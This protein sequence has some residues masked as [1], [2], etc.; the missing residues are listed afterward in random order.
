MQRILNWL[1]A[2][3]AM[4]AFAGLP[5]AAAA[6]DDFLAPEQAFKLRTELRDGGAVVLRW[7]IAPGYHLYRERLAFKGSSALVQPTLPAGIRTFDENFNKEME[8]Y[9]RQLVVTLPL[10]GSNAAP[11]TLTVSY[12]GCADAG[13]CYPPQELA[14]KVDPA[15]PGTL[16]AVSVVDGGAASTAASPAPATATQSA[17]AALPEDD[18][19]LA[20]RTLQSGSLWRIGGAFLVFGLLLSFTPCVLPMVPILSS[21]I[22]G[23]GSVSRS[24]GLL[25]A[26]AYCIG[27]ALVYTALG[28]GAG[29]AGEGLAGALQ[30]PWVLLTFGALLVGLA[31][32]M[33]DVY[34]LQLP[35]GLQSRL[36]ETGGKL[37]GGRFIGV[38]AMGAL[39]ALIVGPCVAG[40]LAGALLYISQTGNA[41]IGGWALFSMACGMSVPLLLTGLSAGSL[42]PRAGAWMNG[43]KK[44]F[45]L[46]LIAV[47]VWMVSPV[48]PVAVMMMLWGGLAILCAVFLHVGQALPPGSKPGAYAAKALGLLFLVGGLFELVGA[49]SAGRDV[50]QPLAHLRGGSANAATQ[51]ADGHEEPRFTRIRT[52][53][54]LETVLAAA[55]EPVLLDFYADW[56]VACKEMERMTFSKA[57]VGAEMKKM[58]LIQVDVTANNAD[59]RALMKKFSLFGPPGIILFDASGKELPQGRL[60]GFIP[61]EPFIQQLQRAQRAG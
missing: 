35:S 2:L 40:P 23:E 57:A 1:M 47:A 39:S 15:Q 51:A 52:V 30:K 44:V 10:A 9:Q 19:T 31:L 29:L 53:A 37:R 13:L 22:V 34:Q 38:F 32:S 8:T 12:Q 17:A 16:A 45:G 58:R 43:V 4:L 41:W 28:V 55:K 26:T 61:P 49:A 56:C 36:S 59:D 20:Q 3:C 21:I 5:G 7:D 33:F 25:L 54:E 60:I 46:L 42:L 6:A 48:F 18:S 24:R 27:M 50:L 14:F 11:F